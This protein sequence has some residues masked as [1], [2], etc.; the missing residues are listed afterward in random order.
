MKKKINLYGGSFQHAIEDLNNRTKYVEWICN[1]N[2]S[3]ISFYVDDGIMGET[4]N[5][6]KNYGWL[7]E[8]KT[9]IP[10]FYSW[11]EN[12][13]NLLEDKFL[14]VF[15]H[16][17]ELS[18]KSEV[19]QLTQCDMKS[20]FNEGEIHPKNKLVSMI[21]SNKSMCDE[22]RYRIS[23]MNKYR[24]KC[25]L[26]GRGVKNILDKRDGLRDYCFSITMENATYPNMVTEKITDCFMTGTIPIYYGIKNI[27][28]Y[29]NTDGI[30][31]LNDDFNIEDLSFNL[32]FS[33]M[34]AIKENLEITKNLLLAEDY[35]C[36]NYLK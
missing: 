30:I 27:G 18:K 17:L 11:V 26:Y 28:D 23:V 7:R 15:T 36:L 31:L 14:K 21:A 3:D 12:N 19:F 29:F 4:S 25:D 32:Y 6:T 20:Y 16:D 10:S 34:E 13:I 1:K 5:E 9:I 35:I 33:K 24:N 8:S 22:H 2:D